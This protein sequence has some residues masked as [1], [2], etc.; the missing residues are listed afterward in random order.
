MSDWDARVARLG[1]DGY[2]VLPDRL[3]THLLEALRGDAYR[4][5]FAPPNP[6]GGGAF[7]MA[8][9][10]N[11]RGGPSAAARWLKSAATNCGIKAW[12][13]N[14]VS[15]QR[16]IPGGLG[17]PPHRDQRY[18]LF[19]IAIVTLEGSATFGIHSNAHPAAVIDEWVTSPSEVI[20]LRGWDPYGDLD[21]RPYHRV[22]APTAGQRVMFQVPQ[23]LA[24][25]TSM[26]SMLTSLTAVAAE[27]SKSFAA[28]PE[29]PRLH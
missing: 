27:Q 8:S 7:A 14:E 13:P 19:C 23:N 16:Y 20:L 25:D 24:G 29:S 28:T 5:S 15:Y 11:E 10:A 4:Y 1:E 3:P 12:V 9:L 21:A 18:Y 2:V 17:L 6:R 26:P 22:D